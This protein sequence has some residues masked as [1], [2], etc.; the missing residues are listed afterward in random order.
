[1]SETETEIRET[2]A[3]RRAREKREAAEAAANGQPNGDAEETEEPDPGAISLD[4][5][6]DFSDVPQSFR[7]TVRPVRARNEGQ[8]AM[9]AVAVKSYQRWIADGKPTVWNTMPVITYFV[10][11]EQEAGY[12]KLIRRA[13]EYVPTLIPGEVSEEA[14]G[15]RARFGNAVTLTPELAEKI[16]KPDKVGKVVLAWVCIDKRKRPTD[17]ATAPNV[18]NGDVADDDDDDDDE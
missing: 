12:R 1:M 15:T 3:Q 7:E 10:A 4:E 2:A 17:D 16:G 8:E 14:S 9:D 18:P 11:P 5:I 13:C 6:A